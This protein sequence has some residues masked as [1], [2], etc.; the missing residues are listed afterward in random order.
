VTDLRVAIIGGGLS[1]LLTALALEIRGVNEV[2]V[3]EA[4]PAAGGVARTLR[5]NGYALE[6]GVGS[7]PWPHPALTPLL[8]RAGIKVAPTQ[9]HRRFVYQQGQLHDVTRPLRALRLLPGSARLRALAEPVGRRRP[10]TDDPSL[11]EFLRGRLGSRAG[12][13]AAQLMA[14][15]VFAGDPERLSAR[16]AFPMLTSLVDGHGSLARGLWA[17]RHQ[18]PSPPPRAHLPA[19]G[20]DH[21]A[22]AIGAHLGPRLR[23]QSRVEE[24]VRS[25]NAYRVGAVTAASVVVAVGGKAA[26]AL[27][28]GTVGE[29]LTKLVTA[30]VVVAGFSAPASEA[31]LPPGFGA[32]IL[33][34]SPVL[35]TLFE[36]SYAPGRAPPGQSFVKV[37]AGGARHPD[38][39]GWD[40]T[41]VESVLGREVAKVLSWSGVP[42]LELTATRSIPQYPP[43]HGRW[44]AGLETHLQGSG[45][46]LGGW[47]YRGP[48]LSQLAVD[49]HRLARA[50]TGDASL[51]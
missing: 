49:A 23:L 37:I 51:G 43:G 45:I 12:E 50:I 48:G 34:S 42:R 30:P 25:G 4:G 46:H 36:S 47:C 41:Q 9:A 40:R 1:G 35:G 26:G 31:P 19:G 44:L 14:A 16:S 11:G 6:P 20:I 28:G 17:R 29:E 33:E 32:L 18:R 24:L 8:E 3:F 22:D 7:F 10:A 2:A 15:G 21:L 5:S 27:V 13:V 39:A 38:V